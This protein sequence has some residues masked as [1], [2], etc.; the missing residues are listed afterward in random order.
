[1]KDLESP[2]QRA[3]ER[4]MLRKAREKARPGDR[5]HIDIAIALFVIAGLLYAVGYAGI[6]ILV[7]AG[8]VTELVAWRFLYRM[9][10]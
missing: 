3:M 7:A 10:R 4:E 6:S 8:A 2:E 9:A 1:M 5:H